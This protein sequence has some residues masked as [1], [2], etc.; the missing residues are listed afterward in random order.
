MT[1]DPRLAE[2]L[3]RLPDYLGSHVLV[4]ITA[5]ALG[6]GVSLPLAIASRQQP[7]LRGALLTLASVFQTIPGLALLALLVIENTLAA[8]FRTGNNITV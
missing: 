3:A 6:L 5:L 7:V 2:A 8:I 4:S 1:S